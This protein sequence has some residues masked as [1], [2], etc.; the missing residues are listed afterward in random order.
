MRVLTVPAH[1]RSAAAEQHVNLHHE[2]RGTNHRPPCISP[3]PST[4][5]HSPCRS[6]AHTARK[7]KFARPGAQR[8]APVQGSVRI[9]VSYPTPVPQTAPAS[10][11]LRAARVRARL[12]F[13]LP[14]SSGLAASHP[15]AGASYAQVE[16]GP[17]PAPPPPPQFASPG[18][19][20]PGPRTP[21]WRLGSASCARMSVPWRLCSASWRMGFHWCL[22]PHL[23]SSARS[24][25]LGCPHPWRLGV[26]LGAGGVGLEDVLDGCQRVLSARPL[27][28]RPPSGAWACRLSF[29]P[30]DHQFTP[31]RPHPWRLGVPLGARGV[32]LE[33]VLDGCQ[34]VLSARPL[35]PRPPSGAWACRLSFGPRDHQFTPWRPHPWRLGVPLG[36]RGVGLEDVLDGCQR[37]LSARPLAPR[38]PSGA[39]ACRLSFGPRDHQFTPWRP[40][41]WRLGM[42][43]G[44]R[45][46][47]LEDV[48]DGC[49]RG[50][51][52]HRRAVDFG[53]RHLVRVDEADLAVGGWGLEGELLTAGK[54]LGRLAEWQADS[55]AVHAPT[56]TC[57]GL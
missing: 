14:R 24:S 33:D 32:G 55:L 30:R 26:P 45:G 42:P 19:R 34:R 1:P 56:P 50:R 15:P 49:Q 11:V 18:S 31:W 48:L 20:C 36:A 52:D 10:K 40:H 51:V 2:G 46:V 17:S 21:P 37:V 7:I 53:A 29:G 38:P 41:P 16:C 25:S 47:G 28:P 3:S 5:Q 4:K 54:L 23:G 35:A 57:A 43:F 13:Q 6:K 27:A 9:S 12:C 8:G 22:G 39:W 44:A